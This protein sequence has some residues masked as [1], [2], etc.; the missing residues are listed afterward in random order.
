MGSHSQSLLY[1]QIFLSFFYKYWPDDGPSE[2]E[3][4]CQ[5]LKQ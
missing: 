3:T 4:C 1:A 2:A 5:H